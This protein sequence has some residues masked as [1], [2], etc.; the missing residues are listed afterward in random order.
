[1]E[2]AVL[3]GISFVI[4]RFFG[5]PVAFLDEHGIFP[6]L[7]DVVVLVTDPLVGVSGRLVVVVLPSAV[8]CRD[9]ERIVGGGGIEVVGC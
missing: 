5:I 2:V 3:I 9:D 1:V 7:V 6:M 8:F 4:F